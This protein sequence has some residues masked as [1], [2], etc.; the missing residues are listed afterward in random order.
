MSDH[1]QREYP[2]KPADV[3]LFGTCLVDQ[4]VPDAGLDA[5]RLLEREGIRVHFPMQQACCG[6]P[7]Y[8]S[9]FPEEA[10]AVALRQFDLFPQPWPIIVL[11][12]SCAGMM[13]QHY[14]TLFAQDETHR[15]QAQA[16][17]A[18]VFE[19]TE[20]LVQVV[21][22]SRP[23]LASP[24]TVALHTSCSARREMNVHVTGHHL[25]NALDHVQVVQHG[26]EE[27]CCGFG[28]LFSLRH[29]DISGAIANDK[30]QEI[31]KAGARHVVSADCGCLL[32]IL[33]RATGPDAGSGAKESTLT[34]EHIA[35]FL[36]HRTTEANA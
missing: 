25:L 34:G 4:F 7:A 23:D 30:V 36:W 5:I 32:N 12:G 20:F 6:Q 33:G 28:G 19:F 22:F 9:G 14:P 8:T 17:A 10:R 21:G 3:Y 15:F 35:S 16:L 31:R 27:E 1:T 24:T 29:P 18:R 11:S 26:H 2:A 13:R